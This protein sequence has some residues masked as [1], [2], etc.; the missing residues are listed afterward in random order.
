LIQPSAVEEISFEPAAEP[1]N[2]LDLNFG[3][4][5]TPAEVTETA[6]AVS[7]PDLDLSGISLDLGADT[8]SPATDDTNVSFADTPAGSEPSAISALDES[9]EVNTKLDLVTAYMEIGDN[10][11]ARELLDE[12]MKEGG[13]KQQARAKE[14]LATIA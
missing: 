6:A 1:D 7:P 11:G 3:E 4:F 2:A 8:I 9:D 5:E 12:V 14:I 13:P 10:E